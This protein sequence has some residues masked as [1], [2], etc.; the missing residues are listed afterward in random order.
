VKPPTIA[1][2]HAVER[3]IQRHRSGWR[4][5]DAKQELIREAS[6]ATLHECPPGEDAIWRTQ[7]GRLL[8][9][10][11][12]GTIRTVLPMGSKAP[13]RRPRRNRA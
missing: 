8:C 4:F 12:D 6:T 2:R 13:N 11:Y 1:S 5:T 9:V 3:Y 10:S 7:S